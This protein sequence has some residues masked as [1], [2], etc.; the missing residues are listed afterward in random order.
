M[1]FGLG[2]SILFFSS[3]TDCFGDLDVL[4]LPSFF[5]LSTSFASAFAYIF[6]SRHWT[7]ESTGFSLFIDSSLLLDYSELF[8]LR[9]LDSL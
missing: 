6:M 7:F 4:I 9:L 5:L 8:F 3:M 2:S 1:S